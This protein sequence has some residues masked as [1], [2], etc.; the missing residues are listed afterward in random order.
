MAD[1]TAK[2][3][4]KGEKR[5]VSKPSER[6]K[7]EETAQ[8]GDQKEKFR[9][10]R[11][12][13][14]KGE[15]AF[16]FAGAKAGSGS[17]FELVDGEKQV[18]AATPNVRTAEKPVDMTQALR[19]AEAI[20]K[21]TGNDN[22][23][24]RWADRDAINKILEGKTEAERKAIDRLYKD[25]YGKGLEEEMRGFQTGSD[26]EKFLNILHRKDNN[27]ENTAARR[28]HE[29][30]VENRNW[31]QG[32]SSSQIE[33]DV[34]DLLSTRSADQI[35]KVDAEYRKTYGVSLQD[36]ILKDDKLSQATKDMVAIYLKGNDKRTDT[37]TAK[38][39]D[40]ALQEEDKDLFA[41]SMRD[42]SPAARKAFLDNGGEQKVKDAFG[43]WYSNSDVTH[44]M[45]YAREGKLS[46]S[47]Q[48][49]DNTGIAFDNE[50]GVE[51]AINRMTDRERKM[52]VDGKALSAGNTIAGMDEQ[53]QK[54]ARDYYKA[55]H[56]ALKETANATEMVQYEDMIANKGGG[57]LVASLARHR[58]TFYNSSIEDITNDVR[59]MTQAQFDD[60]KRNP[61]QRAALDQMLT[62]LNKDEEERKQVLAVYDK[63]VAAPDFAKAQEAGKVSVSE[64]I[65]ASQH[66]YGTNSERLVTSISN[67]SATDQNRYRTDES[68]RKQID[69]SVKDLL[70]NP[71]QLDA[72]QRM[73]RQVKEG[74]A[75]DSDVVAL[76]KMSF[77]FEGEKTGEISRRI[78][79]VL[80]KNPELRERLINPK[81]EEDRKFAEEFRKAAQA[82]F[83]EDY[84]N[85]GKPLVETGHLPLE[86]KVALNQ[87]VFSN[88]Y[89]EA[90]Q[91]LQNASPEEKQKLRDDPA[92]R[93]KVLGWMDDNRRQIAMATINQTALQPEDNIRAA[94]VGWG[95]SSDI[96]AELNSIKPEDLARVKADYAA[97]YG[98][99]LAGDL[100]DKLGGQDQDVAERVLAQNLS[101]EERTNIA[102]SQTQDARS[103]I[104]AVLS[105]SIFRSGTGEQADDAM[106]QTNRAISEQNQL[107]AAIAAGNE[108]ANRM[109]PEQVQMLQ[110]KLAAQ[111]NE[112][113]GFQNTA[114]ENAVESKKAAAN[115]V[116]DGAII[117]AAIG[118]IIL[119]GGADAPLVIGLAFAGAGIKVGTN[120]AI[121]GNNYELSLGQVGYDASIG[122]LTAATS[123]IGP[124]QIAAVF[125]IGK[126]AATKA[127]GIA[128]A[129]TG[130]QVLVQGGKQAIETGTR[131][132]VQNT[133]ASGAKSL[134]PADFTALAN[135]VV[136]PELTGA[137]REQAVAQ[138]AENLRKNVSEQL[139]S[140]IVRHATHIGL[141]AG[142][143]AAG[144]GLTGAAEGVAEWDSRKT[145][146]E[147]L[148][149][150]AER[151][152]ELALGGA[153]IGG[154]ISSATTGLGRARDALRGA[155]E[156]EGVTGTPRVER[157]QRPDSARTET[158][159]KPE[160]SSN[161]DAP[162]RPEAQTK[163]EGT[164]RSDAPEGSQKPGVPEREVVAP[165]ERQLKR[166]GYERT[167]NER[168]QVL[169]SKGNILE[170][171]WPR[172]EP[173]NVE[174]VRA[175]VKIEL[176]QVRA[177]SGESVL[178]K[179]EK[180]GLSPE[181]QQRVLDSL[182]EVREHYAR[183]FATDIDQPVNWIHTQG[184]LGRVIDS[185]KAAGLTPQQTEDALLASM[186]SDSIKTKAN[187]T[188]H[189]VDGELAAEH[190]LRNKLG[191]EF[192]QERL[193][194]ILHAIREHQ[195]APPAFMAMIYG[196]AIRK[197]FG[198]ALTD[199]ENGV[200]NSLLKKMSDP[201]KAPTVDAPGGGRVLAL[202][203]AEREMLK[204]TGATEWHVP[205]ENTPWYKMSRALI[206]GDGIDNYATP[207]G[208]SKIV[209]IRGPETGP[210]FKDGNFRFENPDRAPGAPPNSSQQSWRDSFNDFANVASPD[211][212][213]IARAAAFDAEESAI[214]AQARVDQ[215]LRERL[216]VPANQ[217]LPVIPGWTGKP[218]LD[219]AGKPL[220]G[221]NGRVVVQPDN[222]KYPDYEPR[223]WDIHIKPAGART[224]EEKAFYEDPANRYRGLNEQQIREFKLAQEIRDRYAAELR[225]EQRVAGDAAPDYQP[226]VPAR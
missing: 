136:S 184:E 69:D 165:P 201:F 42:A 218:Q 177:S 67:M 118:S 87:G 173:Q 127:A 155:R 147:N 156:G 86:R 148:A 123:V 175:Q 199:E 157:R 146:A 43:H 82:T 45:D 180:S 74:R 18:A 129:E 88:A 194:G 197:G 115:Y 186:F 183:T 6:T 166:P 140:G 40:I 137:A 171:E 80:T 83:R 225:K 142:G 125:G 7:V 8:D 202:T 190:I 55:V 124:G 119:T 28:I 47:T 99:S 103:G 110:Q 32:R 167:V 188:T 221:P 51:L 71:D 11:R 73:L 5:E 224:A 220:I 191:G 12:G 192:T 48:I 208:L 206:D 131:E 170:N 152:G 39:I 204:K 61:A 145:V 49:K 44:A 169:D 68:F 27:A 164:Q 219:S 9:A 141:N 159:S 133:L 160:P 174:A 81:T 182:G 75:P 57:S 29:D 213:R 143:G 36:A 24:A 66:W 207:G 30:L 23:V 85:Y 19:D 181:Q 121:Q 13:L 120:A 134:N 111:V 144:G 41:E 84:E 162:P 10:I 102:R 135:K 15:M 215:W 31:I 3:P 76:L 63:M 151:S 126:A 212:L 70:R 56:D 52:Y 108:I 172:V 106:E 21:A 25:K 153:V 59:N 226:V 78:D 64:E 200:L 91:D 161:A 72:A 195:I 65:A 109:S 196:G 34:R 98:S 20:R 116:A 149:H 211:G 185:A 35:A 114:T 210:F 216:G 54:Q 4:E 193:D 53:Q 217:E 223:W 96:V 178:S 79:S 2:K 128:L 203:D 89:K 62:S 93:D 189:H 209:Q 60:A 154:T 50:K 130:E 46:A 158:S 163:A 95:G 1:E 14:A 132:I 97:K 33:K 168:G 122:S 179:L 17:K 198:R 104:G 26:L 222:V 139:A 37:D 187:F 176:A 117:T 100:M 38:L 214:K 16:S 58:G 101:V 150:I 90:F 138:L 22:W 113:I 112:A 77:N 107:N 94:I 205:S 92:Y 105:D